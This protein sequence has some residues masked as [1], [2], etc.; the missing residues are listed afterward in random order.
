MAR[1]NLPIQI[2]LLRLKRT[3]TEYE[4]RLLFIERDK[5]LNFILNRNISIEEIKN[6][7][8]NL[9]P[10]NSKSGPVKD[11]NS[12]MGGDVWAFECNMRC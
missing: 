7:L 5:N 10:D 4:N 11:F 2:F 9:S 8:L 3:L 12:E 1:G 6:A